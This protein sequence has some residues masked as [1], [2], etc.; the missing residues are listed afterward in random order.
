MQLEKDRL[1]V[2]SHLHLTR[3]SSVDLIEF[4]P[5]GSFRARVIGLGR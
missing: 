1:S 3:I 5:L 2:F 4:L